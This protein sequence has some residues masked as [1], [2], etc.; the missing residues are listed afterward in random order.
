M[1]S[2]LT[3]DQVCSLAFYYCRK[4]HLTLVTQLLERLTLSDANDR[5]LRDLLTAA[6][7]YC[8]GG[9]TVKSARSALEHLKSIIGSSSRIATP[10]EIAIYAA[11]LWMNKKFT[12]KDKEAISEL[13]QKLS[14]CQSDNNSTGYATSSQNLAAL[15]FWLVGDL[16]RATQYLDANPAYQK[17]DDPIPL[18]N[19]NDPETSS[20]NPTG[21]ALKGWCIIELGWRRMDQ[22]RIKNFSAAVLEVAMKWF[23]ASL[24]KSS[25][26]VDALMGKAEVLISKRQ[27]PAAMDIF[28][29]CLATNGEWYIPCALSQAWA[30]M[31]AAE[32]DQARDAIERVEASQMTASADI[33]LGKLKAVLSAAT[34]GPSTKLAQDVQKIQELISSKEPRNPAILLSFAAL[35][36]RLCATPVG[37]AADYASS[38]TKGRKVVDACI[39]GA[40]SALKCSQELVSH[41]FGNGD[42]SPSRCLTELG[43]ELLMMGRETEATEYFNKAMTASVEGSEI[44]ALYGTIWC[45]IASDNFSEA[46]DQLDLLTNISSAGQKLADTAFLKA[47]IASH[48]GRHEQAVSALNESLTLHITRFKHSSEDAFYSHL[49]P[50]F[51]AQVSHEYICLNHSRK[52][53][54]TAG[55]SSSDLSRGIKVLETISKFMPGLTNI[56]ISIAQANIDMGSTDK[57]LRLL[58]QSVKSDPGCV[59]AYIRLARLYS[60]LG[61][62]QTAA[63]YLEQG[64]SQDFSIRF[65]PLYAAVKAETLIAGNELDEAVKILR[66]ALEVEGVRC[67]TGKRVPSSKV[68]GKTSANI[69]NIT[70]RDRS[71]IFCGLIKALAA[72]DLIAEAKQVEEEAIAEFS[73]T[74]EEIAVLIAGADVAIKL[75]NVGEALAVLRR[76]PPTSQN[77]VK[78]RL[79]MADI[80]KDHR[81]EKQAYAQCYKDVCIHQPS[82]INFTLLGD[83]YISIQEPVKAIEAFEDAAKLD[84]SGKTHDYE[85]AID[86]YKSALRRG[87]SIPTATCS[88]LRLDLASLYL[89]L[90]RYNDC[91]QEINKNTANPHD[92]GV[93]DQVAERIKSYLLLSRAHQE[94]HDA[95]HLGRESM[96]QQKIPES[97]NALQEAR[98]TALKGLSLLGF[99]HD[100]KIAKDEED[101]SL[102]GLRHLT[103]DVHYQL[104]EYLGK[105]EHN[106]DAAIGQYTAALEF[107]AD[108]EDA[109]MALA[110][111]HLTRGDIETSEKN[112]RSLLRINKEHEDADMLLASVMASKSQRAAA[113]ASDNRFIQGNIS[114]ESSDGFK[115]VIAHYKELIEKDSSNFHALGQLLTLLRKTG[116]LAKL[117]D[118]YL[119]KVGGSLSEGKYAP[120]GLRYCRGLHYRWLN[121]PEEA[122]VE[123]SAAR[124][125]ADYRYDATLQMIEIYLFPDVSDGCSLEGLNPTSITPPGHIAEARN[126]CYELAEQERHGW[127]PKLRVLRSQAELLTRSKP[128]V[129][130]AMNDL[131]NL[132]N[133]TRTY[134]PALLAV[135]QGLVLSKQTSKARN[136]LKRIC[137]FA[138]NS[139]NPEFADDFERAWLLLADIYVSS[140]KYD[141]ATKLCLQAKD[142]NQSCGRA[143]ELLGLIYEKEQAYQDAAM[144]YQK[145]WE[146]FCERRAAVG[147]RLAFNFLKAKRYVDAI[148]ICHKVLTLDEN[149]PKIRKDVLDKARSLLRL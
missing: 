119:E 37:K 131:M 111:L 97:L 71:L 146:I 129:D 94:S 10:C 108:H 144:H 41:G 124:S 49:N 130:A 112:L 2:R 43:Y 90:R 34:E 96:T 95:T 45:C 109:L 140:G 30:C 29:E 25:T 48:E 101:A 7:I 72:K 36:A 19:P 58:V 64:L 52:E 9:R 73:D 148:R 38:P 16:E 51:M 81:K 138:A 68:M 59:E 65:H 13:Q 24:R 125:D 147:Y 82:V 35:M 26:A 17:W 143:W 21:M 137:E 28:A 54:A 76:V 27:I 134:V 14:R 88:D 39:Q 18:S 23:E 142:Q 104:G 50:Y 87:D 67:K 141:L 116:R 8:S 4:G 6:D 83:T 126:L 106:Y 149:Y 115:D 78:A 135:S 139:Y 128:A 110:R 53:E 121:Q 133:E 75:G 47:V 84:K 118:K 31:L 100:N 55:S 127:T 113:G 69:P 1:S 99:A 57:A 33:E 61:Q 120:S 91:I 40:L 92:A 79:A 66:D 32:F 20:L 11:A 60:G 117:G 103:A 102:S 89:D 136:Q 5:S 46:S 93:P 70:L 80:Y 62:Q 122:I 15:F 107:D 3:P 22:G 42:C 63:R 74:V 85:K 98:E 86:Y 123:F 114:G 132:F 145:A 77:F 105:R 12:G 44:D 56:K